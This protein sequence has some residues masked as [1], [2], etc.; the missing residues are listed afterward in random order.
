M[1]ITNI[2]N[3]Y[4]SSAN[5]VGGLGGMDIS[6]LIITATDTIV[7]SLGLPLNSAGNEGDFF[8]SKDE[9]FIIFA[10]PNRG[11]FGG[12]DLFISFRKSDDTWT[13]PINL[14]SSINTPNWD[15]GPYV[16]VDNKYLFYTS[17]FDIASFHIYWVRFDNLIDSLKT[18]N[19]MT[20]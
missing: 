1:Q 9:S 8:I 15:F 19:S 13:S 10:S 3:Y 4:T 20:H 12:P 6:K 14:G 16:T 11:G 2:G 18:S 17:G 5:S 7:K